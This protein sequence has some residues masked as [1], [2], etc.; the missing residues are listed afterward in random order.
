MQPNEVVVQVILSTEEEPWLSGVLSA[1]KQTPVVTRGP[2]Y[3]QSTASCCDW[4]ERLLWRG[5]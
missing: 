3:T 2:R 4:S 5:D 1:Q